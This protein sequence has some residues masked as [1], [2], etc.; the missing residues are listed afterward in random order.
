[1][2][3]AGRGAA[4]TTPARSVRGFNGAGDEDRRKAAT[5]VQLNADV[6]SLQRS[7]R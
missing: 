2:K 3:I 1:M 7:R 6:S 5:T 4:E